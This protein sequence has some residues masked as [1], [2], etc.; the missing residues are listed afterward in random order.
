VC[1]AP[2]H[3]SGR[4]AGAPSLGDLQFYA[5]RVLE[6][7]FQRYLVPAETGNT[8]I[9]S[10]RSIVMR[11]RCQQTSGGFEDAVLLVLFVVKA[12]NDAA[13]T[14]AAGTGLGSVTVENAD[15]VFFTAIG[16]IA[17]F[18]DLVERDMGID[19]HGGI[20]CDFFRTAPHIG[21]DDIV[22]EAIHFCKGDASAHWPD[23]S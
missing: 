12:G 23:Q 6:F 1:E 14:V 4:S 20:G 16:G 3:Q 22:A 17:N 18:H 5:C 21:D 9:D 10:Y 8:H 2:D 15:G 13:H 19:C 11:N 7:L